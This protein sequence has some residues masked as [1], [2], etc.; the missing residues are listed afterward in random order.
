MVAGAKAPRRTGK[1]LLVLDENPGQRG[2]RGRPQEVVKP[3][4]T[5]AIVAACQDPEIPRFIPF[6]PLPYSQQDGETWLAE[7]ERKWEGAD[8]LTFAIVDREGEQ[9]L[10]AVP[11]RVRDGYCATG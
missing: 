9:F 6:V 1:A 7:V 8:E 3:R 5:D 10:G 2:V 4:H 11:I